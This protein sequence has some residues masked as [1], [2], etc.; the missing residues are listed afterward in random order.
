[1]LE[2]QDEPEKVY[3][4]GEHNGRFAVYTASGRTI[5]VCD[6]KSSA[7]HYVTLLNESYKAGYKRGFRDGRSK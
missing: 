7:S 6:E 5:M 4:V 2:N 1:M 3:S